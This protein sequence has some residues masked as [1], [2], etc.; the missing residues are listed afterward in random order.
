[1]SASRGA[2]DHIDTRFGSFQFAFIVT[3]MVE[4]DASTGV[5]ETAA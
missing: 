4:L 5:V 3:E 1:V 2:H